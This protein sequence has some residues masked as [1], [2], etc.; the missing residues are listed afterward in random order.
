MSKKRKQKQMQNMTNSQVVHNQVESLIKNGLA[1]AIFETGIDMYGGAQLSKIDT[2][3]KNN[4]WYLLSNHRQLLSQIYVEHGLVRSL[5]D[6]PVD[7]ALRGGVTISSAQLSPEEIRELEIFMEREDDYGTISEAVKWTRLFGGGGILI[8]SGQNPEEPL[9]VKD[10]SQGDEV[11]FRAVDM[12]ELFSDMNNVQD[13][14]QQSYQPLL[15]PETFNY[16]GKKVHKTRVLKMKGMKAPSLIR[17]RLRGW[18]FSVVEHLVR[19]INQYLK[20][21]DLSFDVLDEFKI[22]VYKIKGL[23]MSLLNPEGERAIRK[24]VQIANQEKNHRNAITMDSED[25]YIQKQ[26]SFTGLAEAMNGIREQ[27]ASDMRMP[28][29]KLFGISSAGFNSGEDDIENYNS[30]VEGDIRSKIKYDILRVIEVRCLQLFGYIPD[31]LSIEF[32]PLRVLS[33]EQEEQVKT[34]KLNR[35]TIALEKG[36]ITPKQAKEA[37]NKERLLPIQVDTSDE[38]HDNG[39]EQNTKLS[40][41]GEKSKLT[42][43]QAK[44]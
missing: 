10:I 2:L 1:D 21:T 36:I 14:Q 20:S 42:P 35:V 13:V 24:R 23:T 18:G 44:E 28:M 41:G 40:T 5:V 29:T 3:M 43:P 17:P 34:S 32:K 19:S 6:T 11:E 12:W 16:Y 30:M 38:L 4:R 27:I 33:S 25:D 15:T 26:V 37:I 8:V 7:D 22:D 9:D 39:L 31:D